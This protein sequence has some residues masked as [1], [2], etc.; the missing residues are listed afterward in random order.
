MNYKVL[1]TQNAED[2]LSESSLYIAFNTGSVDQAISF[3]NNIREETDKLNKFPNRGFNP[4]DASI[5]RKGYKGLI[6]GNYVAFYKVYETEKKVV[7]H[8]FTHLKTDY[9]Y[10]LG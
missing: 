8:A 9:K 10:L 3:L 5:R 1:W 2:Q 7:I 6:I 4:G